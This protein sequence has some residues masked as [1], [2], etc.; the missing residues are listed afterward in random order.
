MGD[1][2]EFRSVVELFR[3]GSL[4]PVVDSVAPFSDALG[5]W[6]RLERAAQFGNLVVGWGEPEI[7]SR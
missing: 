3:R 7:P 4:R 2:S 5:A 6:E 1:M